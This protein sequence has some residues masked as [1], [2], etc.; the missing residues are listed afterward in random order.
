MIQVLGA[1]AYGEQKAHD[2]AAAE[3]AA[4]TDEADRRA[5]RKIAAEELRHHKGFVRRLEALGADPDR[6]MAPY[7][8]SLDKYHGAHKGSDVQEAVWAYLGEGVADDLLSWLRR[9]ADADTAAF[10]D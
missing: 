10:I 7:R 5:L 3:A 2:A 6:A 8:T 1:I 4:A 9:V